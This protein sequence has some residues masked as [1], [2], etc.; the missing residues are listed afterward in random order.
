MR[1][2]FRR[3]FSAKDAASFLARDLT[4]GQIKLLQRVLRL[5]GSTTD[6][7]GTVRF[8][9]GDLQSAMTLLNAEVLGCWPLDQSSGTCEVV[10]SFPTLAVAGHAVTADGKLARSQAVQ[11]VRE[12]VL[13]HV[14]MNVAV[15]D[16]RGA[17]LEHAD[18]G[19]FHIDVFA[20]S[21]HSAQRQGPATVF[22]V[23]MGKARRAFSPS[24]GGTAITDPSTGFVVAELIDHR[25]LRVLVDAVGC[26]YT[27]AVL[28]RIFAAAGHQLARNNFLPAVLAQ[29]RAEG[30]PVLEPGAQ[31][32]TVDAAVP[33]GSMI[34]HLVRNILAPALARPVVVAAGEP[35]DPAGFAV[36]LGGAPA[37]ATP[38][39]LTGTLFGQSLPEPEQLYF[40]S[41]TGVPLADSQGVF[42]GELFPDRLYIYPHLVRYGS[43]AEARM[44]AQVLAAAAIQLVDSAEGRALR[45]VAIQARLAADARLHAPADAPAKLRDIARRYHARLKE[46]ERAEQ[47]WHE[48]VGGVSTEFGE[49]FDMIAKIVDNI[50]L[51]DTLLTVWTPVLYA[52]HAPDARACS[53]TGSH[54]HEIGA[55][56]IEI[57]IVKDPA[58]KK[59]KVCF[60]NLTRTVSY[61]ELYPRMNAPHVGADGS[62]C[63]GSETNRLQKLIEQR[64]YA[65]AIVD[66]IELLKAVNTSDEWG[67]NIGKWPVAQTCP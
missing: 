52:R 51:T 44:L 59:Y 57:D 2:I 50:E 28:C 21:G 9:A 41:G 58:R 60:W 32:V 63:L 12:H 5:E 11:L 18:D 67:A 13:A 6:G 1:H 16:A 10:F 61:S 35:A 43:R 33:H 30:C 54:R 37:G 40:P 20:R 29:V 23:P 27:D 19:R 48:L 39:G 3:Q 8:A 65:D 53:V 66:C 15:H 34:E 36:V 25:A 42:V 7:A 46:A 64:Q 38:C 22:G 17:V 31:T 62:A 49:E 45:A 24:E 47:H 55:F 4:E 56:R 26:N 14:R